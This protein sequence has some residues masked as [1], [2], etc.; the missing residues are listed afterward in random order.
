MSRSPETI[1]NGKNDSHEGW[2]AVGEP[3]PEFD[4]GLPPLQMV[5]PKPGRLV[6]FPSTMWHGTRPFG[7]GE[8]LTCAFDV[9]LF[10][11]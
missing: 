8:R 1:G 4:T 7:D 5:E 10:A 3:P 9:G 2:L 11:K 6:L